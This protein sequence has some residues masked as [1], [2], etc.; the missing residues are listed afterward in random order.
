MI[1][2]DFFVTPVWT[3]HLDN[4]EDLNRGLLNIA[5]MYQQG[6]DYFS[7]ADDSVQNLKDQVLPIIN[8]VAQDARLPVNQIS[9]TGR[10]NPTPPGKNNSPHHHP[11]CP[12]AVVYYVRVPENSGD[13]LL[14]DPRGAIAWQDPNARTDVNWQSYR[15]YHKI[16]PVPGMLLIFPGYVI[17]SVES[18]L[19]SDLR[20]SIAI[21]T[22][23]E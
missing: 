15:P 3:T 18:N 16:T 21:S 7:I 10:Q 13:I 19:S 4:I 5:G 2:Q 8:T 20:L 12:L 14:H 11:D 23:F 17:H 9:I 6:T 1:R 22:R